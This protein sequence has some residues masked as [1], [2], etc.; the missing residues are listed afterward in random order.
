[1]CGQDRSQC[2]A[3]AVHVRE[4]V[5]QCDGICDR[6]RE[7]DCWLGLQGVRL[8]YGGVACLAEVEDL[9]LFIS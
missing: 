9:V 2:P 7:R 1:M 3:R 4:A 6:V 8:D 5:M